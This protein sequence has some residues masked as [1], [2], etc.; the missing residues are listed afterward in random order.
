MYNIN[1]LLTSVFNPS[2]RKEKRHAL[3]FQDTDRLSGDRSLRLHRRLHDE[4]SRQHHGRDCLQTGSGQQLPI[5]CQ[6]GDPVGKRYPGHELRSGRQR[7]S[8]RQALQPEQRRQG[9]NAQEHRHRGQPSSF[10]LGRY[11]V[12]VQVR[13]QQRRYPLRHNRGYGPPRE[14]DGKREGRS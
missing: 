11:R 3:V 13:T 6:M 9:R 2:S 14:L 5:P 8:Y 7:Q 4:C 10:R 1:S 12:A